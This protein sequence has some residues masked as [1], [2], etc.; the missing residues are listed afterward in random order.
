[1]TFQ[2]FKGRV[3]QYIFFYQTGLFA[4]CEDALG[5]LRSGVQ[6][7]RVVVSDTHSDLPDTAD[8]LH[9]LQVCLSE[10]CN[11]ALKNTDVTFTFLAENTGTDL[12]NRITETSMYTAVFHELVT[13]ASQGKPAEQASQML[14]SMLGQWSES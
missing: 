7:F 2:R 12:Q 8:P 10:P 4:T 9:G 5:T 6:V 11:R 13:A 3:A 1:M 14:V